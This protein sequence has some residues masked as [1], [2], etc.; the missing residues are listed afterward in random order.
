M[1]LITAATGQVGGQ[2]AGEL[3][4]FL[5]DHRATLRKA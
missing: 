5:H 1:I 3:T 2:A 4:E